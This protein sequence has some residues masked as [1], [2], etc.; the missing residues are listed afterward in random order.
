MTTIIYA[1]PRNWRRIEQVRT[2]KRIALLLATFGAFLAAFCLM[3]I[4]SFDYGERL[5]G[6]LVF[7]L[8]L[9][10][11]V[12]LANKSEAYLPIYNLQKMHKKTE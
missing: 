4:V 2:M 8:F 3:L 10:V 1:R 9:L 12:F 7:G 11:A 6:L 5:L